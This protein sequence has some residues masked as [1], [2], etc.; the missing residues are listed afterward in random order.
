MNSGIVFIIFYIVEIILMLLETF[1]IITFISMTI[2]QVKTGVPFV[3]S[4]KALVKRIKET[5]ILNNNTRFCDLGSGDGS[6]LYELA[7]EFPNI[8]FVGYEINFFLYIFSRLFN[9]LPNLKFYHCDFFKVDLSQFD[10]IYAF[11]LSPLMERLALKI[12]KEAKEN[13]CVI[14]NTFAFK[15]IKPIKEIV[16]SKSLE[17]L[18]FYQL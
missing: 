16:S 9:R 18:Y 15:D 3:K 4:K 1:F 6:F 17:S 12:K 7:K 5:N 10:Y 2:Y 11:L 13:C 14:V 8:Q